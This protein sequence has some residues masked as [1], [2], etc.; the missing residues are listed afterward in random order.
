MTFRDLH[1]HGQ[2]LV[3][4]N[5]WDAGSARLIESCG[6]RAIATSSAVVAWANGY[7]DG[8]ALPVPMLTR[9]IEAI[10]RVIHIPLSV[11]SEGG[12][13]NDPA[14]AGEN[15]FAIASAGAVGINL[16][17]SSESPDLLCAKIEAAKRA[18]ERAGVDLFVN[19]RIDVYLKKLVP[20]EQALDEGLR[21]A[22]CYR[23]AGCDGIFLPLIADPNEIRTAV[24]AVD[25]LPLN[26][27]ATPTLPPAAG[28]RILGVRRLSAGS[29]IGRAATNLTRDVARQFL[30]DGDSDAMYTHIREMIDMNGLFPR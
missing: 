4:A 21:R 12:Y 5:A 6:A 16:E 11:D 20:R 14:K 15:I 30:E 10:T 29:A 18:G 8:D 19:A 3:L 13:S 17:D 23:A 28:L 24:Q 2:L 27:L 7:P 1:A 9:S 26:V 25:P 22:E